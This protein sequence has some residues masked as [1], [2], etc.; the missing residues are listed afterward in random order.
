VSVPTA[1]DRARALG[2]WI[3]GSRGRA[4]GAWA[5]LTLA[6][7]LALGGGPG[8]S[9]DEAAVL[10]AAD[11]S[12]RA[13]GAAAAP[14]PPLAPGAAAAARLALS[15]LG[16]SRLRA[17]RL[18]SAVAGAGLSAL[19]AAAA[20]ELSGPAAALLAPALFWAAPRH[21]HA[22]LVATP[23]LLATAL[24]LAAALAFRR[25]GE[26]TGT[27]PRLP[28]AVA[29]GLL[30]G[31]ALA[32]RTDAWV[33]VAALGLQAL[34]V[35]LLGAGPPHEDGARP[36][37]VP[38][39]IL[40]ILLLA[41]LVLVALWPALLWSAPARGA[42]LAAAGRSAA[43]L[44]LGGA[45]LPTVGFP[46]SVTALTVPL[47]LL[48]VLAGGVAHAGARLWRALVP[49][50]PAGRDPAPRAAAR[51]ELWLLLLAAAPL[52]AAAAGLGPPAGGVRP[53]LPALPFLA[54]LGA[55]ALVRAAAV[56]WPARAAPLVASLA[57]LVVWPSLRATVHALPSGSSGWNE[58]A[59]GAPGA[60]SLAL[61]RQDGGEGAA[62]LVGELNARAR[63]GA[64]VWWATTSP[65]AVRCLAL[66]GRLRADLVQASG[67]ED[68]DLAVVTL[69]GA[70]RDAE[71]RTW[72]AFRTARPV[73][74]AY[75]DEVPLA[76]AYARP[77]AWR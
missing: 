73:A 15:P 58:L 8:I 9:R 75:L 66:D 39:R 20:W 72:A 69:D 77:G 23:D 55:R 50:A 40:A 42:A 51:D 12:L 68:A 44:A 11:A 60:A 3:A 35:R 70:G 59:G 57:L 1:L 54:L 21:L 62:R 29:A 61:P 64:R 13:P 71:Y 30:L 2:L 4:A 65:A 7:L 19:L 33:V 34:L 43:T 37:R 76:F 32:A 28:A 10:E 67:P 47:A 48:A 5:A 36:R 22:G 17:A 46:L 45:R 63:E 16:V 27:R 38:P 24:V 52:G 49:G 25:A 74:G 31:A 18:P 56:A 6:V 14:Q 41:P 53:W 26:R